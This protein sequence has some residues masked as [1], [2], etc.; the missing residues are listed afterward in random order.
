MDRLERGF[1]SKGEVMDKLGDSEKV[2]LPI[3]LMMYMLEVRHS[4]EEEQ[5]FTFQ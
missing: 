5:K 2:F 1:I 4:L 3:P